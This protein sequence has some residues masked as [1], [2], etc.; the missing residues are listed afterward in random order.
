MAFL[1]CIC[2]DHSALWLTL[3]LYPF[4]LSPS[5]ISINGLCRKTHYWYPPTLLLYA[6]SVPISGSAVA[7][8][9][10]LGLGVSGLSR[11]PDVQA[12]ITQSSHAS[13][14][15]V[16]GRVLVSSATPHILQGIAWGQKLVTLIL[17]QVLLL[18]CG[19]PGSN[20]PN[21][22]AAAWAYSFLLAYRNLLVYRGPLPVGKC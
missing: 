15:T 1:A 8:P 12:P 20:E 2:L 13:C 7:R 11:P 10:C 5:I 4:Q 21:V 22:F 6:V 16:K 14:S 18:C 9:C 19:S 3:S 17:H